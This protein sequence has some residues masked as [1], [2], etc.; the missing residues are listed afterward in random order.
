M[1]KEAKLGLFVV[2]VFLVLLFFTINMGKGFLKGKTD[3]YPVYFTNVGTLEVGAPVKQA[4]FDVGE[5]VGLSIETVHEPTPTVYV[6]VNVQ[7]T[8]N[9][10]ISRDSK[11]S[12][13]TLGMMGEKYLEITFGTEGKAPPG[14]RIEGQGPV[15]LDRV[16]EVAVNLTNEVQKT[17]QAFND[18][19]ANEELQRNI[20]QL[21]ANLEQV[22]RQINEVV[23]GEEK[24][25]K[26][27]LAN[28]QAAT[29][30]L[31]NM[32]ATAELFITDARAMINETRP[33]LAK[34]L[35]NTAEFSTTLREDI[36]GP[37]V[38]MATQIAA[39]SSQLHETMEKTDRI[40][41]QLETLMEESRPEIRE[42]IVNIKDITAQAKSASERIDSMLNHIQTGEGLAGKLIYDEELSQSAKT[43]ITK[44]S[45]VMNHV[46]TMGESLFFEVDARY[47]SDRPRFSEHDNNARVDL[48]IGFDLNDQLYAYLGGNNIGT[49]NE[50]EAQFGYRLGPFA[51]HGGVIESELGLG[52]DWRPFERLLIGL[53]G[54]GLTDNDE[55]RLDAYSEIR[56]WNQLYLVGGVQ[57]VT[58]EQFPNI[59][60]KMRF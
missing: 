15:D 33:H 32:M 3:H 53:E 20:V 41:A 10:M 52:V 54:I 55:E 16:M 38:R 8:E 31:K 21:I 42:T 17:V 37:L 34:T 58:A 40:I 47:F 4:G 43:A 57:D 29:A 27:I 7:V 24:P 56:I 50:F 28:T 46:T 39:L 23:G 44:T 11:A 51:L 45:K 18:I 36:S 6:V 9:A 48:G 49:S 26:N 2:T 22:S 30:N 12:I 5:V 1:N 25:L 59:G 60:M 13:Q 14:T 19:I 35:Q